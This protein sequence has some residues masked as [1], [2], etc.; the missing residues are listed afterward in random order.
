ML[1]IGVV[2]IAFILIQL[3]SIYVANRLIRAYKVLHVVL[4]PAG[5]VRGLTR[6]TPAVHPRPFASMIRRPLQVP[7]SGSHDVHQ[8]RMSSRIRWTPGGRREKGQSHRLVVVLV[9]V[10]IVVV[11][12]VVVQTPRLAGLSASRAVGPCRR[13]TLCC[14]RDACCRC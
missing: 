9:V 11:V 4:Y 1:I 6:R 12:V 7:Q 5:S 2:A 14:A 13:H 8:C 10:L 3:C